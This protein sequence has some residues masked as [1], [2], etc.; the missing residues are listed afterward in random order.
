MGARYGVKHTQCIASAADVASALTSNFRTGFLLRT[1]PNKQFIAQAISTF[2]SVWLAPGLFVLF[3]T[4]YP[5][6]THAKLDH[7]PFLVPLVR[8][9]AAVAKLVTSPKVPIPLSSGIFSIVL[10]I[11]SIS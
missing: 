10:G 7:C 4:A 8:S 6:I 11:F 1:P 5:C 9:Y 3:T 2:V